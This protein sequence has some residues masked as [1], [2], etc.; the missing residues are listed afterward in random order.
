MT[1]FLWSMSLFLL[2]TNA[3]SLYFWRKAIDGWTE[4]L[5][6]VVLASRNATQWMEIVAA[7]LTKRVPRHFSTWEEARDAHR[8]ICEELDAGLK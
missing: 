1:I 2:A 7:V 3:A 8:G 5:N 6:N 4:A